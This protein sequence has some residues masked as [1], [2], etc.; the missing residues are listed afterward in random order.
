MQKQKIK[1]GVSII[2]DCDLRP[3][4]QSRFYGNPDFVILETRGFAWSFYFIF[5]AN[6][7]LK[8]PDWATTSAII[9]Q[10]CLLWNRPQKRSG[11]ESRP[12]WG[13]RVRGRPGTAGPRL[14][15]PAESV[16]ADRGSTQTPTG[17]GAARLL[18]R[19][20]PLPPHLQL[21]G[22]S[23][24]AQKRERGKHKGNPLKLWMRLRY[25]NIAN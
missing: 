7:M 24:T 2:S 9:S 21:T 5:F 25:E 6:N 12:P 15:S 13:R 19:R 17:C 18:W 14:R 10:S 1:H 22:E 23:P 11:F 3:V 20:R 4:S 16:S 8:F